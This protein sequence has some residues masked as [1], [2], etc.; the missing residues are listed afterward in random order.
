MDFYSAST[1]LLMIY[2]QRR[3]SKYQY[4]TL[5]FVPTVHKTN[6]TSTLTNAV[7][8]WLSSLN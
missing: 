2:T 4:C 6:Q 1:Y 7:S 8:I 5:W 3:Y